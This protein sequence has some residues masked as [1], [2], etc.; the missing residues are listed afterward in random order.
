ME[1]KRNTSRRRKR[2]N[3]SRR[4]SIRIRYWRRLRN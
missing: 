1:Y 2:E 4:I 3:K